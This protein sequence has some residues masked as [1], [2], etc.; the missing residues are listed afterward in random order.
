M[1]LPHIKGAPR[2]TLVNIIVE[3]KDNSLWYVTTFACEYN[4]LHVHQQR[5]TRDVWPFTPQHL[6]ALDA[7]L[8]S[9]VVRSSGV[10]I[11]A[12]YLEKML[13]GYGAPAP[14]FDR[15]YAAMA[16]VVKYIDRHNIDLDR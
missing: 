5:Q 9:C 8:Y 1:N 12:Q 2:V 3:E 4:Q 10:V 7:N 16:A 6:L 11:P 15:L 13:Y 14:T